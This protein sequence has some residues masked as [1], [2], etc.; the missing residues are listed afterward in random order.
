[1]NWVKGIMCRKVYAKVNF[2]DRGA[3]RKFVSTE[4]MRIGPELWAL[5]KKERR[6]NLVAW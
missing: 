2:R 5:N 1:M 3:I 4:I 6:S